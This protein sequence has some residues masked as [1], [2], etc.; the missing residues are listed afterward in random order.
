[1]FC[2]TSWNRAWPTQRNAAYLARANRFR[3]SLVIFSSMCSR[4]PRQARATMVCASVIETWNREMVS[5]DSAR[6]FDVRY[7][8]TEK[9]ANWMTDDPSTSTIASRLEH[10]DRTAYA[11]SSSRQSSRSVGVESVSKS[12]ARNS[13]SSSTRSGREAAAT[14][15]KSLC[16]YSQF[17]LP[18]SS[19]VRSYVSSSVSGNS[20]R[21]RRIRCRRQCLRY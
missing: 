6:R 2:D 5:F 20:S 19:N 11:G 10:V 13:A 12:N 1:M 15:W 8:F 18:I 16:A 17:C 3:S 4:T 14:H 21:A 7:S 9:C